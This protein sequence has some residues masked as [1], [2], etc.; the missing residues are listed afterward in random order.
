MRVDVDVVLNMV[1]W[2]ALTRILR[3]LVNNTISHAKASKVT[4]SLVLENDRLTVTVCDNGKGSAPA[5]WSHGLGLGGVR[6]RVKLLGGDVQWRE[7]G[8]AGIVCI[9]LIPQLNP[10]D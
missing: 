5:G 3:E 4:V 9:V 10:R 1:Q 6:K 8:R 2:S 7:N